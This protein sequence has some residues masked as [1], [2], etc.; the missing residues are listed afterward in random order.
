MS[1]WPTNA[2]AVRGFRR[3]S[4]SVS[5]GRPIA[6]PT[7]SPWPRRSVAPQ[8]W[9][10]G[11]AA[12]DDDG[13]SHWPVPQRHRRVLRGRPESG[14]ARDERLGR[15]GAGLVA[16]PAVAA[17]RDRRSPRSG[18]CGAGACC[19]GSGAVAPVGQVV[20][21][22]PAT[23]RLCGETV[24]TDCGRGPGT[25]TGIA[26]IGGRDHG[27]SGT[28]RPPA[29]QGCSP[30]LRSA[31]AW[32][33]SPPDRI[34]TSSACGASMPINRTPG[35]PRHHPREQLPM[36]RTSRQNDGALPVRDG[37]R[38]THPPAHRVSGPFRSGSVIAPMP[39]GRDPA[40]HELGREA[41]RAWARPVRAA[42]HEGSRIHDQ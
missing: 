24:V 31:I 1:A 18:P 37:R 40:D 30:S 4:S 2:S 32:T 6:R 41:G 19:P 21:H 28:R 5:S 12:S 7:G 17:R 15:P 16:Q 39:A 36:N 20:R 10:L 38:L 8:A 29:P 34:A 22:R 3:A 9:P 35:R 26:L 14:H 23:G 42:H 13:P 11:H 25:A 27:P 33:R